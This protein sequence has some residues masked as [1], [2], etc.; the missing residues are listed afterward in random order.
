MNYSSAPPQS[1]DP[2]QYSS[3]GTACLLPEKEVTALRPSLYNIRQLIVERDIPLFLNSSSHAVPDDM[4]PLDCGFI[5]LPDQLLQDYRKHGGKSELGKLLQIATRI[6]NQVDHVVFLGIGGSYIGAQA[7]F[8]A[9]L[10][11]FHNEL[12]RLER[13]ELSRDQGGPIPK[14]YFEGNGI[15][16]DF[17]TLLIQ[18]IQTQCQNP[19]TPEQRWGLVVTSKSGSTI[20]TAAA[21]EIFLRHAESYYLNQK[22]LLKEV[23]IPITGPDG[24]LRELSQKRNFRH[25][26]TIPNGVG[27]RFS[28]LSAA[29]LFPAALMGLDII[30]LLEGAASMNHRFQKEPLSN[31]PPLQHAGV[32]FLLEKQHHITTRVLAIWSK[33]LESL[34]WWYDQ[35]LSESLGKQHHYGSTPITTVHTR[36]LHSRGQQHQQGRRDKLITNLVPQNMRETEQYVHHIPGTELTEKTSLSILRQAALQGTNQA[37]YEDQRPTAD[38]MIP[39]ISEHTL[40][41]L[42]QMLMLSTVIEGRL[43]GINPYGQ[44]GV[45]NYKRHMRDSLHQESTLHPSE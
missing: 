40:G 14:F 7:L 25:V 45:E 37:Y 11:P 10:S 3:S 30:A 24:Y 35:L 8:D 20:E 23:V 21:F 6:R 5:H 13:S 38:L 29:G 1:N 12:S 9:L 16:N 28:V 43:H 32:G 33:A 17:L 26:F 2:I 18:R 34:G 4:R 22:D 41:Q 31:N 42:F 36:D 39:V 27:G 15:D 19:E 44:P